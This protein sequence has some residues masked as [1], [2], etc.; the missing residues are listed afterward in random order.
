[1]KRVACTLVILAA[2]LNVVAT[3]QSKPLWDGQ[4]LTGWHRIGKGDWKIEGGA[5]HGTHRKSE[6]DY[7][8]LVSDRSYTNF[9]VR[10]KFKAL[11]G[12]SGFYFRIEEKGW[13]GVSGCQA[14]IDAKND[15]GGLYETNGRGWIV[16]PKAVDVKDWFKP[17]DWNEMVVSAVGHHV[18]V[19]VNGKLT[20]DLPK[21]IQ[22]R[23][24]GKLALQLHAHQDVDVWFKELEIAEQ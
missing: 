1:M 3:D 15:I 9:M 10:F 11:Q 20:A 12:N 19:R 4:T 23:V 24:S 7:G 2:A 5:I 22:G 18:S 17:G 8:H 16:K 21:D 13:S 14:E 6:G